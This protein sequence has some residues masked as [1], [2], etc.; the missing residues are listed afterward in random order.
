M[1]KNIKT[2][3][4]DIVENWE[5][6]KNFRPKPGELICYSDIQQFKIGEQDDTK[7]E[8]IGKLLSDLEFLVKET[9]Y[10]YTVK[11]NILIIK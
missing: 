1:A 6:A 11:E 2:Y 10:N 9:E 4:S 5:K 3:K 7:E 8:G